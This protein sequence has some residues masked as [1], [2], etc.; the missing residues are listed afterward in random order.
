VDGRSVLTVTGSSFTPDQFNG[1]GNAHY[2]RLSS[3][4]NAGQI[5]EVIATTATTITV[6]DNLSD[7]IT[8][9][10]TSFMVTPYWTLSTAFPSGA[11]LTGSTSAT[12][13]D[14]ITIIPPSGASLT[15]FYNTTANQWRRGTTDSSNI[16]IPEGAAVQITRK[17]NRG[18]FSWFIP[19]PEMAL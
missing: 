14:T 11:G 13:A 2:V 9:G 17:A 6:A 18:E 5:S 10:S 1:T 7:V 8:P 12:A 4:V 3:G 19:Q 16:V 15:Y